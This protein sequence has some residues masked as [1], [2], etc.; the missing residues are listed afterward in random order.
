MVGDGDG[1]VCVPF[2]VTAEVLKAAEAK[3]QGETKQLAAI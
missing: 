2:D 1:V 3:H